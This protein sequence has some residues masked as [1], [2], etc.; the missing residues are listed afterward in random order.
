M[1]SSRRRIIELYNTGKYAE[2][3]PLASRLA[4]G[5]KARLGPEHRHYTTALNNLAQLLK[6]TNRTAEAEP[7]NRRALTIDEKSL[8]MTAS[9]D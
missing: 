6:D 7:V 1:P 9:W 4:E 2:A 5:M 8:G 3:I